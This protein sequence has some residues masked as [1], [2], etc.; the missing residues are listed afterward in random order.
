MCNFCPTELRLVGVDPAIGR[1][2]QD[3][4]LT[5]DWALAKKGEAFLK[6]AQWF[7]SLK[8]ALHDTHVAIGSSGRTTEFDLGYARPMVEP[9]TAFQSVASAFGSAD[10][11][12]N[13]RWAFVLGPED[14]GLNEQESSLCSQLIRIPTADTNPSLNVAVAA[15]VVLYDWWRFK[16]GSARQAQVAPRAFL[17]PLTTKSKLKPSEKDREQWANFEQCDRFVEYFMDSIALTSFLKYPDQE[18][19]RAR[20]RRWVQATPIPLGELLFAFEFLYHFRA[21][22]SGRFEER[23]FLKKKGGS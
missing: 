6:E 2:P 23:D 7:G 22:G 17:D 18:A 3:P 21:W 9:E 10:E 19:V 12:E 5:M 8:E 16:S 1:D 4:F 15:A 13:F 20:V 11:S 14:D